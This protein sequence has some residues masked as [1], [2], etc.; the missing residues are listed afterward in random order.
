MTSSTTPPRWAKLVLD[1]AI[2]ALEDFRATGADPANR[3][4]WD[5]VLFYPGLHAV[6]GYRF[7][8]ILWLRGHRF[9]AR[10][11]S[12]LIRRATLIEIHPGAEI[13]GG[14]FI[15]HGEGCVIGET[16]VVGRGVRLFHGVT[17]GG[18]G[19]SRHERRH[20]ILGDEVLVG[21]KASILG[22]V[23]IGARAKIGAGAVVL[24]DVGDD[25]TAVGVP[26]KVVRRRGE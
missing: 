13:K 10:G 23:V 1:E 8:R 24:S 6:W 26:A 7:S 19:E 18:V 14:L 3:G 4:F 5:R 20:P 22:P 12:H 9:M 16:S 11:V 21:A 2:N 15:D 25:E 17:L